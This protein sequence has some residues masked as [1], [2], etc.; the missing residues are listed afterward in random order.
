MNKANPYAQ[1]ANNKVMS[2]SGPELTLM[3]YE[4]AIKFCNRAESAVEKKDIQE[5]HNNIRKVQNIVTYLRDTL[6]MSYATAKDF[7]NIYAYL[8]RRLVEANLRKDNEILKEINKHLHSVRDTW[9]GVM[10]ANNVPVPNSYMNNST[11]AV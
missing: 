8:D 10:K 2:A 3:L 7:D 1:Y 11:A 5:A 9:I 6:N 4:G